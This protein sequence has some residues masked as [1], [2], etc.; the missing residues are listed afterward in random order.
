MHCRRK[1]KTA[2]P[3]VGLEGRQPLGIPEYTKYS[4]MS[5]GTMAK[6]AYANRVLAFCCKKGGPCLDDTTGTDD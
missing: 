2:V 6:I 3:L 5:T 1:C 4:A